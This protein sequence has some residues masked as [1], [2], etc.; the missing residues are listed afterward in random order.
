VVAHPLLHHVI[1]LLYHPFLMKSF[2]GL[3]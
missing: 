2:S 1:N 3:H